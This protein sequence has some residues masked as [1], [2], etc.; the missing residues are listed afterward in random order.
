M[1][2][3]RGGMSNFPCPVCLVPDDKLSFSTE[4][5][6]LRRVEKTFEMLQGVKTLNVTQTNAVLATQG[7]RN[8]EV[9]LCLFFELHLRN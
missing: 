2:L 4:S 6:S 9:S 1:A 8:V 3:T 5:Y 7:L